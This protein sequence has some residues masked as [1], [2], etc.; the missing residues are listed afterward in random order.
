MG[1]LVA[2]ISFVGCKKDS[3]DRANQ[4]QV[5]DNEYAVDSLELEYQGTITNGYDFWLDL[6]SPE[7]T[8]D[9]NGYW[10]NHGNVISFELVSSDMTGIPS[11]NYVF[12][13][14]ANGPAFSFSTGHYSVNWIYNNPGSVWI[15]LASGTISVSRNGNKYEISF[16]GTDEDGKKVTAYYKGVGTVYNFTTEKSTKA[17][18]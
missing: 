15:D 14:T 17:N 12:N 10:G 2:A 16:T 6:I 13:N 4:F 11:G 3:D 8:V 5:A 9:E 7:V 18:N 1:I